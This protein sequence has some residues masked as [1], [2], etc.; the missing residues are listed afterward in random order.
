[1]DASNHANGLNIHVQPMG[2][3][4]LWCP[5][6]L[7]NPPFQTQFEPEEL[8]VKFADRRRRTEKKG[9]LVDNDIDA[10][11][12]RPTF[13]ASRGRMEDETR[14]ERSVRRC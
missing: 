2:R 7:G 14:H 10:R 11:R 4:A 8:P 3:A 5:E 1:M 9:R 13:R 6:V 12:N